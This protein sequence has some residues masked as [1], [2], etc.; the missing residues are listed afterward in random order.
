[1]KGVRRASEGERPIKL[2]LLFSSGFVE[3]EVLCCLQGLGIMDDEKHAGH[4]NG[5]GVQSM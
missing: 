2:C 5:K 1:M 4:G 3:R